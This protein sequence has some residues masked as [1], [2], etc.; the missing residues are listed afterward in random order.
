MPGNDGKEACSGRLLRAQ[1]TKG[2]TPLLSV[3]AFSLCKSTK[4][5]HAPATGK[6][7]VEGGPDPSEQ[8][9]G[10]NGKRNDH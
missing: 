10:K 9:P 1:P 6:Q 2:K 3:S 5:L 4:K 8:C 7:S